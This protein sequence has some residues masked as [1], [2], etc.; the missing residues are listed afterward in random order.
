MEYLLQL[1][2]IK[3]I[4][5]L[6]EIEINTKH[7]NSMYFFLFIDQRIAFSS[8]LTLSCNIEPQVNNIITFPVFHRTKRTLDEY[9]EQLISENVREYQDVSMRL[10]NEE[11]SCLTLSKYQTLSLLLALSPSFYVRNIHKAPL[12]T[13]SYKNETFEYCHR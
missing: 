11:V 2:E 12:F 10:H 1:A 3:T 5:T 4:V 6:F 9:R 8:D 7:K 13:V